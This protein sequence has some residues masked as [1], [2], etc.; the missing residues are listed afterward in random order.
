M[1]VVGSSIRTQFMRMM[2]E[3]QSNVFTS[4]DMLHHLLSGFKVTFS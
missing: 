1:S 4:M 2:E 3:I